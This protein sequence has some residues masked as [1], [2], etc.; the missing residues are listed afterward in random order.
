MVVCLVLF[1]VPALLNPGFIN[2]D[3]AIA[4]LQARA[5]MQGEFEPLHWGR[6]YL[7]SIDSVMALPFF[8]LFGPTPST[9]IVV[10]LLAQVVFATLAFLIVARHVGPWT[11]L[12]A[13]TPIV[14]MTLAS[15]IYL[16][17]DVRQWS[18]CLAMLGVFFINR[19]EA[20]S[21]VWLPLGVVTMF[22]ADF[23]DLY[24]VQFL[25]AALLFATLVSLGAEGWRARAKALVVTWLSA[26]LGYGLLLLLRQWAHVDTLR[27]L[28][29]F[30]LLARN[31]GFLAGQALPFL[32]GVETQAFVASGSTAALPLP[33]FLAPIR[34]AGAAVFV[35]ALASG[36]GL[37]FVRRIPWRARLVGVTGTAM[38]C[39]SLVGFLFSH[40]VEDV[41]AARLLMPVVL[42]FPLAVVPLAVLLGTAGR[43][44]TGLWTYV[45]TTAVAGWLS[46]GV[47]V[48]GVAPRR[49]ERGAMTREREVSA[50]LASKE[51]RQVM[52]HYWVAY[53][54]A[55]V[56][57]PGFEVIP[58]DA[59][60]DRYPRWRAHFSAA[61][62][63]AFVTTPEFPFSAREA[64]DALRARHLTA[65]QAQVGSYAVHFALEP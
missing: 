24:T 39:T 33:A 13:V 63:V 11:S 44:L 37:F 61:R 4:G 25:P 64:I 59:R 21:L 45:L 15:N 22:L 56:L 30:N 65:Q 1:R 55:F 31:W 60:Q 17:F 35:L 23:A 8:A 52:A 9:I 42:G 10:T 46:W 36:A 26:A 12:V 38:A 5:M 29:S 58:V 40:A 47:M 41:W 7:T 43:L 28:T 20:S 19:A 54:L 51:L 57:D 62:R 50:L 27:A 53:R 34:F 18:V 14:F 32:L 6:D 49:T 16:Y 2:S 3:G 48:D